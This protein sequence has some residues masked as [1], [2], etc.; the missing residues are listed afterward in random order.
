MLAIG[1]RRRFDSSIKRPIWTTS[2]QEAPELRAEVDR[3]IEVERF[4]AET[5]VHLFRHC[6]MQEAPF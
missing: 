1:S 6:H 3:A 2:T 4:S 5:S